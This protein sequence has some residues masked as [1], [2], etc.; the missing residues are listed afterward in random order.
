MSKYTIHAICCTECGNAIAYSWKEIQQPEH[1]LCY[2]C[3]HSIC[4]IT[5]ALLLNDGLSAQ[6]L[7]RVDKE[8]GIGNSKLQSWR[9][10]VMRFKS[11][12]FEGRNANK[13]KE[14][15]ANKP[16]DKKVKLC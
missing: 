11:R 1:C 13:I 6:D 4:D 5:D 10:N 2:L 8:N 9:M 16:L 3:M 12:L 7:Y 14:L 15:Q